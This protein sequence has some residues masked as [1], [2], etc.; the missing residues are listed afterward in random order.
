RSVVAPSTLLLLYPFPTRRS[1]DLSSLAEHA[2]V[3][4]PTGSA[5][6]PAPAALPLCWPADWTQRLPITAPSPSA[7]AVAVSPSPPPVPPVISSV[8]PS[9]LHSPAPL[10]SC[11]LLVH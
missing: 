1:S 8:H 11:L 5:T 2:L 6:D 10:V 7:P 9:A 3:Q 4:R